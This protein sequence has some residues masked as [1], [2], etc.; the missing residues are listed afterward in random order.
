MAQSS[1]QVIADAVTAASSAVATAVAEVC[2]GASVTE[3]ATTASQAL[4]TATAD[5]FAGASVQIVD[6]GG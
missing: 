4:A 1:S 3:V 5:A 6:Q 2:G